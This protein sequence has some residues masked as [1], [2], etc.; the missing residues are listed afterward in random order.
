MSNQMS[1]PVVFFAPHADDET[2]NMGITIAEHVA[3]GR[4]THV[5]LM[6]H[7]RV[8]GVLDMLN[9]SAYSGYWKATHNPSFEGYS[10]LTKSDLEQARIREFH[11]ACAQLGVSAANR[12]VEY[13]DDPSSTG[14]ESITKAEAKAVIQNYIAAYPDADHFTLSYHD[15]HP[16]HAAVGQALLDLY[17]E[18]KIVNAARFIISMATRMDYESRGATIPGWKDT[19][20]NQTIVNRL[21]NACRCYAAWSPTVGSFA[22]GYHSVASQ[23]DKLLQN[24]YHYIHL[25]NA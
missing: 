17:N 12:H 6:T 3:A 8:T 9:G 7:G 2:L 14:G 23:F 19:P 21:T 18:G 16:D 20:T 1:R 22:V 25:P 24:P 13:L 11:H 10:P 15:I 5:V 4:D